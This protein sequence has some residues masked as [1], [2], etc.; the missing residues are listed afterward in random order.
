MKKRTIFITAAIL[1]LLFVSGF[2]G[3]SNSFGTTKIE[4]AEKGALG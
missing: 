4:V 2:S 3:N 1:G